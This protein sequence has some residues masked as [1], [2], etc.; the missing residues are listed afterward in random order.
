MRI[1]DGSISTM[2]A[3]ATLRCAAIAAVGLAGLLACGPAAAQSDERFAPSR[4]QQPEA[5]ETDPTDRDDMSPWS[6]DAALYLWI[7]G[8]F[9]TVEAKGRTANIGLSVGGLIDLLF[10]RWRAL[11]GG[12]HF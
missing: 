6:F 7:P 9:G 8:T 11:D 10:D 1:E 3:R 4:L 2:L 12:G 5:G